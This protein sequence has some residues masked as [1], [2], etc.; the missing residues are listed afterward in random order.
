MDVIVNFPPQAQDECKTMKCASD[1]PTRVKREDQDSLSLRERES[2]LLPHERV[3]GDFS[4]L[5][6][7]R[8]EESSDRKATELEDEESFLYG[9][10]ALY[11]IKEKEAKSPF[12]TGFGHLLD[13]KILQPASLALAHSSPASMDCGNVKTMLKSWGSTNEQK[14]ASPAFISSDK[15]VASLALP[16]LKNP[17]VRQALESL[18]SLIQGEIQPRY[19]AELLTVPSHCF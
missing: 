19:S 2:M 15:T 13:P 3:G 5:Q 9:D 6:G 16:A 10:E 17:N 12:P 18:Q 8:E 7:M 14:E 1:E 4:W 11:Q